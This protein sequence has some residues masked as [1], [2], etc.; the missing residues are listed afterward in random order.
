M[1]GKI[2]PTLLIILQTAASAVCFAHGDVRKG[3]Y[4]IAAAV[5]NG[6]VTF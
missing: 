5:V 2:F 4:W 6:A 3:I 1:N